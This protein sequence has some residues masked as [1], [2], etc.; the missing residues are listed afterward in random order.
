MTKQLRC[1]SMGKKDKNRTT[2][3]KIHDVGRAFIF[4]RIRIQGHYI[5]SEPC[6]QASGT[7]LI[8]GYYLNQA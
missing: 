3:L 4:K 6:E 1:Y 5:I 8:Y 7:I 2:C